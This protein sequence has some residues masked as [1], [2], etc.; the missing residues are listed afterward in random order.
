[1]PKLLAAAFHEVISVNTLAESFR[2]DWNQLFA[3]TTAAHC[4]KCGRQF[5]VF[6]PASD[7]PQNSEYLK[8]IEAMIAD[9]CR[10]GKHVQQISLGIG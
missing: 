6:F 1:M 3:G 7:D 5:A 4:A 10:E 9:D 2:S 8:R